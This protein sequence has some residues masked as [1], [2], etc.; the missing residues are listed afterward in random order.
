MKVFFSAIALC[1]VQLLPW[2]G[3][4]NA[5]GHMTDGVRRNAQAQPDIRRHYPNSYKTS[6]K[7]RDNIVSGGGVEVGEVCNVE[8]RQ[9]LDYLGQIDSIRTFTQK[10]KHFR[11]VDQSGTPGR[12]PIGRKLAAFGAA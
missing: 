7:T 5:R 8:T 9:Q 6:P 11:I 3:P 12:Q 1:V 2:V 4:W 10:I